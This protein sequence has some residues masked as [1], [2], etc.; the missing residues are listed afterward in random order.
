[1]KKFVIFLMFILVL[2]IQVLAMD[3]DNKELIPGARNG[4]LIDAY[5]GKI[6]FE[7]NKDE[8]VAVASMT[9]M[10]AQIIILENIEKGTIKWSDVITVSKNA[11]DMG[12][13]QIYIQEGKR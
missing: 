11:A 5:S 13:S 3:E 9:K 10:V 8:R 6:I 1:M 7:R 2:P 12:G 4:I